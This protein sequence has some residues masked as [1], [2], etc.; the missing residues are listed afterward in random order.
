M[1][2]ELH[3]YLHPNDSSDDEKV[4]EALT[5]HKSTNRLIKKE[6]DA[7][8]SHIQEAEKDI[9]TYWK[10][11]NTEAFPDTISGPTTLD[12]ASHE[13]CLFGLTSDM[14]DMV[15]NDESENSDDASL[16]NQIKDLSKD[17]L[18]TKKEMIK[19][20]WDEECYKEQVDIINQILLRLLSPNHNG[21][22]RQSDYEVYCD[23]ERTFADSCKLTIDLEEE[24]K[25]S[26]KRKGRKKGEK[27]KTPNIQKI[28]SVHE[29][30]SYGL[31]SIGQIE[32]IL[33][34][35]KR[36]K[37][38]LDEPNLQIWFEFL[39]KLALVLLQKLIDKTLLLKNQEQKATTLE[40]R[41]DFLKN[42]RYQE[43]SDEDTMAL[44][45]S[46]K[47]ECYP[48]QTLQGDDLKVDFEQPISLINPNYIPPS[49]QI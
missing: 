2:P 30:Y 6:I 27:F 23:L 32:R 12:D 37:K 1:S 40:K 20:K 44:D 48:G 21:I 38:Y 39:E 45:S 14:V 41:I 43:N 42:S 36:E 15:S 35:L 46:T 8:C 9:A 31:F 16:R 10:D 4:E 49:D 3:E 47:N 13:K 29:S 11:N 33:K 5:F 28:I 19:L 25:H 18:N 26:I 7:L 22:N 17:I 34:I 24:F